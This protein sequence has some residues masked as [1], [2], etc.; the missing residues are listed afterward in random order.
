MNFEQHNGNGGDVKNVCC[1]DQEVKAQMV[2]SELLS[3]VQKRTTLHSFA[4]AIGACIDLGAFGFAA[5]HMLRDEWAAATFF[6]L[7][8]FG[9]WLRVESLKG[10]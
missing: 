3:E 7:M 8:S 9:A 6:L 4:V 2:A 10:S 1:V 5:Y